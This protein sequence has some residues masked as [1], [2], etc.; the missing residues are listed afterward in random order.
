MTDWSTS[1]QLDEFI[2]SLMMLMGIKMDFNGTADESSS[3]L[4]VPLGRGI[5]LAARFDLLS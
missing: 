5:E 2:G 4:I 3:E 1:H